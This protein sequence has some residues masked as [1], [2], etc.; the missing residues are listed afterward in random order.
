M[1]LARRNSPPPTR[2]ARSADARSV[3]ASAPR[4]L[5]RVR[6]GLRSR[7]KCMRVF[8]SRTP[9]NGGLRVD[10][11]YPTAHQR[12]WKFAMHLFNAPWLRHSSIHDLFQ[13]GRRK[14]HFGCSPPVAPLTLEQDRINAVSR[15]T[16]VRCRSLC[17]F[18]ETN[19]VEK[20][21]A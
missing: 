20:V 16:A 12:I 21:I 2:L 8:R 11:A 13:I 9:R 17:S 6:F 7:L 4:S 19:S 10:A 18:D 3:T 1:R 15:V 14:K 5:R